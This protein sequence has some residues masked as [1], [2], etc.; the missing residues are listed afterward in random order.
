M[1]AEVANECLDISK[2]A[3]QSRGN[4]PLVDPNNMKHSDMLPLGH[5]DHSGTSDGTPPC[6]SLKLLLPRSCET[7]LSP[8]IDPLRQ[9]IED[10]SVRIVT[11]RGPEDAHTASY[12]YLHTDHC[13]LLDNN[14]L[15]APRNLK[16]SGRD[17]FVRMRADL[18]ACHPNIHL[19]LSNVTSTVDELRAVATV[20][21]SGR[22]SG[23]QLVDAKPRETVTILE[24]K[25][26]PCCGWTC[27]HS[28]FMHG[29][30]D[31]PV[32]LEY[33]SDRCASTG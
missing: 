21:L 29:F 33:G 17:A 26:L 27:T 8:T 18:I 22:L 3:L 12:A 15:A 5:T 28:R 14:G 10:T 24:W 13:T 23:F 32:S 7:I 25:R 4:P 1:T 6:R 2:E 30:A 19:E 9:F 20:F 31:V 11:I 16:L